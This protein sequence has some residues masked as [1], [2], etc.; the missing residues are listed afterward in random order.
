[1]NLLVHGAFNLAVN[2]TMSFV[3]ALALVS[4]AAALLRMKHGRA[5][6]LLLLLPFAKVFWDLAPGIGSDSFFWERLRGTRHELG[7]FRMGFGVEHFR[8][9]SIFGFRLCTVDD[10]TG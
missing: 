8:P 4:A 2:A 7:S 3:F 9:L 10:G 6:V 1:V 5:C